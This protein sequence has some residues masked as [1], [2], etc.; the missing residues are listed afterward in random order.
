MPDVTILIPT[1]DHAAFLPV[2]IRSALEQRSAS[3]EVFVVGDGVGDDTRAAVD[4]F[5][6]DPRVRF[7]DFPKGERH[8][9]RH[10]HTALQEAGSPVVCYLSDDDV[11]LPGHVEEMRRL[12]ARVDF[13]HALPVLVDP[14]EVLVYRPAD[15]A[16]PEYLALIREG[17]NNFIS[18]TGA[19][20]TRALY[21]R[22]P[23]GWRPAPPGTPTDIHMWQQ[24]TAVPGITGATGSRLTAIHLPDPAWR[25][26]PDE[27]RVA[28]LTG[29]LEI[30]LRPDGE[31]ELQARLDD[32]ILQAAQGFKLRSLELSDDLRGAR[33]E[34]DQLRTPRWKRLARRARRLGRTASRRRPRR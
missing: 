17:R 5:A 32:A 15:L 31:D 11:L 25:R 23:H 19:A 26:V 30:A 22:L 29:W 2:A 28:A 16:R 8:G 14:G 3:V 33:R 9:E 6:G 10:R 24:V 13:A 7:F 27:V 4:L 21:E 18:L 12:L 34:L 20:H 1:H